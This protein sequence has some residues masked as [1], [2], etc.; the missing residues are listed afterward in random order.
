MK[1]INCGEEIPDGST[2]CNK[3]GASQSISTKRVLLPISV[4]QKLKQMLEQFGKRFSS[5]LFKSKRNT[6]ISSVI[7]IVVVIAIVVPVIYFNNPT[8]QFMSSLNS[9]NAAQ[10]MEIYNNKIKGNTD[11]ENIIR[12][13][14]INDAKSIYEQFKSGKTDYESALNKLNNFNQTDLASSELESIITNTN[15]LNDS[16]SAFQKGIDAEKAGDYESAIEQFSKVIK[17]D[18]NYKDA[19]EQ[20]ASSKNKYISDI[21]NKASKLTDNEEIKKQIDNITTIESSIGQDNKLDKVIDTLKQ[22]YSNQIL[23]KANSLVKQDKFDDALN[24]LNDNQ[25]YE[26]N[27]NLSSRVTSIKNNEMKTYNTNLFNQLKSQL[28]INYDEIEK[29]YDIV[30]KGYETKYHNLS[31]TI[32]IEPRITVA[33]SSIYYFLYTGFNQDDWIFMDDIVFACDNKRHEYKVDFSDRKTQV[34]TGNGIAE[35]YVMA[36]D[37]DGSLTGLV[38]YATDLTDLI[39]DISKSTNNKIRFSGQGFRDHTISVAEKNNVLNLW[40]FYKLLKSDNSLLTKLS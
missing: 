10:A 37:S 27:S 36:D 26:Y 28:T 7:G 16:K 15:A 22:K 9:N 5:L 12:K 24:L 29:K 8:E 31:R 30:P 6:I 32:N 33:D 40:K 20:L 19:T 21:V 14:L 13:K 11:K 23:Q 3:C 38:S 2:F 35:W 25:K 39:N 17:E 34:L 1:C 18:S 4:F